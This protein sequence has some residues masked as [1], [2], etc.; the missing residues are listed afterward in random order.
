MCGITG[1]INLKPQR[2]GLNDK[3][4]F[5]DLLVA[6]SLRGKH[7]TGIFTV[8]TDNNED[9]KML[10]K[11][12][13]AGE[14]IE[15]DDFNTVMRSFGDQKYIIGHT[16]YAT[17]GEINDENAHPF[18]CEN[19]VLVH[20]GSVRNKHDICELGN[21]RGVDIEV[22]S[23]SL[24]IA[25]SKNSIEKFVQKVEG[26]FA[27]VWYDTNNKKLHFIR[28][29]ERPL[30]FGVCK[31]DDVILFA[32]EAE[33]LYFVAKRN[34][35]ELSKIFS[36][37]VGTLLTFDKDCN[38]ETKKIYDGEAITP[39][40]RGYSYGTRTWNYYDDS[41]YVS[42]RPMH[43]RYDTSSH[44]PTKVDDLFPDDDSSFDDDY[45]FDDDDDYEW[46]S[47]GQKY[48][49]NGKYVDYEVFRKATEDGCE[50]CSRPIYST[51][52]YKLSWTDLNRPI[53]E[54]CGKTGEFDSHI[55]V[56][57]V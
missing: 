8:P 56:K 36:L 32:S 46:N 2:F 31:D 11:A 19:I 14:F 15:T 12:V 22:D 30:H 55:T 10:K 29:T 1:I 21:K 16:R 42:T 54:D 3:K 26:A 7:S 23:E 51:E 43:T 47:M 57:G 4:L 25:L 18:V 9:V 45:I 52:D 50:V 28:N 33:A 17:N 6:T 53:C 40:Y 20:N 39:K 49:V 34:D 37:N 24:A 35:V 44:K 48:L 5:K 38:F 13:C 27:I 41:V